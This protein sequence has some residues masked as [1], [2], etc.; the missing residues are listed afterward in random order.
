MNRYIWTEKTTS[1]HNI[2]LFVPDIGIGKTSGIGMNHLV[3]VSVGIP[4]LN[5]YRYWYGISNS[6]SVSVWA[7]TCITSIRHVIFQHPMGLNIVTVPVFWECIPYSRS[8]TYCV[9]IYIDK[10][11]FE[12][13]SFN[14]LNLDVSKFRFHS[15]CLNLEVSE[16][17]ILCIKSFH[18]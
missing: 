18:L 7:Y 12:L 13:L 1:R 8:W 11:N 14:I 9:M 10:F 2:N 17:V 4:Y 3:S 16:V 6:V 15:Q 5:R